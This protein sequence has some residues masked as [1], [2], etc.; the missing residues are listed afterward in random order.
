MWW[1]QQKKGLIRMSFQP[2]QHMTFLDAF[3]VAL[4]CLL[5]L[6]GTA[7]SLAADE[8][9]EL[10]ESAR[11]KQDA[12]QLEEAISLYTQVIEQYPD[13]MQAGFAQLRMGR[14]YISQKQYDKALAAFNKVLEQCNYPEVVGETAYAKTRLLVRRLNDYPA[15]IEFAE[16]Q[17][18]GFGPEMGRRNLTN[19]LPYLM[20]AYHETGQP[21]KA[22]A[23]AEE[24][25][26]ATPQSLRSTSVYQELVQAQI[27]AGK[28]DA[29]LTTARLGYALCDF[30]T[31]A[32]EAMSALVRKVCMVTGD[33]FKATQFFAAQEDPDKPN[34]LAEVPVP[35]VTDEQLDQM[36][37]GAGGDWRWKL[38]A[39]L[40]A[41]NCVDAMHIAQ[42]AMI[43]ADAGGMADA[44]K[45]V[46]RVLKAKDLNLVR[47]N[48]FLE[49]AKTGQG[50][51]PL[52]SFWE[53]VE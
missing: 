6:A 9:Q 51:N 50:Q 27:K 34:P 25:F 35:E 18:E 20:H 52:A 40:Y 36:L 49:Y 23:V 45:E 16:E 21:E 28:H 46:A 29:A 39:Y 32:I 4:V 38:L 31:E 53:E 17:L 15:A 8:A 43:E 24:H 3:A 2:K 42:D 47:A 19:L 48:Q 26:L 11:A 30:D 5:L 10:Y 22:I 44:L 7:T 12:G 1:G 13:T 37:E 14:A 41:G 33:I